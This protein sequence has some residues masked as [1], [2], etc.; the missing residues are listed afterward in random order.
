MLT[1]RVFAIGLA[2]VQV[3]TFRHDIGC[4]RNILPRDGRRLR[5]WRQGNG[6]YGMWSPLYSWALGASMRII[7][8]SAANE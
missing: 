7:H 6:Y 4:G 2:L 5:A 3:W 1:F 8:P